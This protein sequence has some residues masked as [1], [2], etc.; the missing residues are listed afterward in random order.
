MRQHGDK[1]NI[2][3]RKLEDK[4]SSLMSKTMRVGQNR[5]MIRFPEDSSLGG[6]ECKAKAKKANRK[7]YGVNFS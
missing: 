3:K 4:L 2:G 1:I 7:K 5:E 6:R